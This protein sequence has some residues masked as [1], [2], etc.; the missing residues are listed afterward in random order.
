MIKNI[1]MINRI[2]LTFGT[3]VRFLCL[4]FLSENTAK[5]VNLLAQSE[6]QVSTFCVKKHAKTP[7][8]L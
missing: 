6:T 8:G 3:K 4:E 5:N 7:L 1:N 2:F